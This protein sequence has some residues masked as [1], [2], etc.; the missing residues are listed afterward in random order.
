LV[1]GLV[2][3][4]GTENE[5]GTWKWYPF[6]T[7][8]VT[9]TGAGFSNH[10]KEGYVEKDSPVRDVWVGTSYLAVSFIKEDLIDEFWFMINPVVVAGGRRIFEGLSRK[11]DLEFTESRKFN[12]GN[13]A[14]VQT[15]KK[16]G[17]LNGSNAHGLQTGQ[18][19]I[20]SRSRCA[21]E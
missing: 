20:V 15:S 11:L 18:R 4:N 5:A 19:T 2:T 13:V 12:S 7:G 21:D 9:A 6:S 16:R 8:L 14:V 1:T 17:G 3:V 10:I